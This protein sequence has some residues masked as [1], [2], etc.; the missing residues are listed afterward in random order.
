[1][2]EEG[3]TRQPPRGASLAV[4][5]SFRTNHHESR[6]STHPMNAE[7]AWR[8][9]QSWLDVPSTWIPPAT[10]RTAAILGEL[11]VRH[12]VT[13]NTV[14]DAMLAALAVE[15]GLT[16]MS[17]DTDFAR[18]PEIR[19]ENPLTPSRGSDL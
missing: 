10:E 3:T 15:N 14:L 1:M 16:V 17:A 19:W 9:V 7:Q 13:A 2:A 11:V 12:S 18:F 6:I 5:G 4:F 8:C